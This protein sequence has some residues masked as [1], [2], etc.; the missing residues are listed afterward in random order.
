[1]KAQGKKNRKTVTKRSL[2]GE[3][4]EGLQAL[5][6]ERQGRRTLRTYAVEL[7]KAP[8]VAAGVGLR[9]APQERT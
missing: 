3:I 9:R 5:T 4:T 2:F 1:M 6:A 8:E 7:R